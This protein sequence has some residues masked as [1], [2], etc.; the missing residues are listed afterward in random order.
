M[1][2]PAR[3]QPG[4]SIEIV[5]RVGGQV[6]AVFPLNHAGVSAGV[7]AQMHGAQAIEGEPGAVLAQL[8]HEDP[9]VAEALKRWR[10]DLARRGSKPKSIATMAGRAEELCAVRGWRTVS[11]VEIS[12]A[13]HWLAEQR[14]SK[15]WSG[16]THDQAVSALR[17][18]GEFMAKV[19]LLT[20]NPFQQLEGCGEIGGEG[21]RAALTEEARKIVAA[22]RRWETNDRKVK[23]PL[24]LWYCFLFLSGLRTAEA[25]SV[26]WCDLELDG[27]K[28]AV[29]TDPAWTK[30]GR[31]MRVPLNSEIAGLLREHRRAA[32]TRGD[33]VVFPVTPNR[34]TWHRV[35]SMTDVRSVDER[36]RPLTAH[37]CRKWLASE[38]DRLGASPG[39][40]SLAMRHFG[41][42]AQERYV[43][44]LCEDARD[45]FERL[46][47]LWPDGTYER[48]SDP[49]PQKNSDGGVAPRARPTIDLVQPSD[50]LRV[51]HAFEAR[52]C[53]FP[54]SKTVLQGVVEAHLAFLKLVDSAMRSEGGDDGNPTKTD[55]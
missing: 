27:E 37:G 29:V 26:R 36:L 23:S 32:K 25:S 18:W 52:K 6:V 40:V 33:G 42:L 13:I 41:D 24:A 20:C 8:R 46:P 14:A 1:A 48:F 7:I 51:E 50:S 34:H 47:R 19:G 5:V 43:D 2:I 53:P 16:T 17:C 11:E 15:R 3:G 39:V 28:T 38:L 12:G 10:E 45:F 31:R 49:E 54:V 30:N 4:L 21:S 9:T 44:R 22:A 35:L 55:S